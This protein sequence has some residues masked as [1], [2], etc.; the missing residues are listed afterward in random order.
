LQTSRPLAT[1]PRPADFGRT[2][3]LLIRTD[4][5]G[6]GGTRPTVTARL[7]N[8]AGTPM[9]DVPVQM[10]GATATIEL[11][12]ANLAAAEYILELTAKTD[13]GSAQELLAFKVD[14]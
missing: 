4:A 1:A 10:D 11:T 3:R 9:N 7:L 2:E 13:A 6:P 14:R 8:R 12:L 5:Y